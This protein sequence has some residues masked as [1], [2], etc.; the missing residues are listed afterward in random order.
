MSGL[1]PPISVDSP[2][3]ARQ[4]HGAARSGKAVKLEPRIPEVVADA[5]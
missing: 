2:N 5:P 3:P 4:Y 1:I